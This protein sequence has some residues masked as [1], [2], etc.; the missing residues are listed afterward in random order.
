MP[1][2]NKTKN[3]KELTLGGADKAAV[4]LLSLGETTAAPDLKH[5]APKEVQLL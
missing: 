2:P 4:L 1:M 5:M 3:K